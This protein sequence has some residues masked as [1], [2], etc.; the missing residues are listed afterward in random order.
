MASI[1]AC[2]TA[3]KGLSQGKV[4]WIWRGCGGINF[5]VEQE[6]K[7]RQAQKTG[8]SFFISSLRRASRTPNKPPM[9]FLLSGYPSIIT[10]A[11]DRFNAAG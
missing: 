7:R 9:A 3:S 10:P 5:V 8:K 2:Q 1:V 6:A 11:P 4:F